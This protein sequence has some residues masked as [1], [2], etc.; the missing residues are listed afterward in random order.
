M[1][2]LDTP[3]QSTFRGAGRQYMATILIATTIT[4]IGNVV[5]YNWDSI[6]PPDKPIAA[7]AALSMFGQW[8][9]R[10]ADTVYEAQS[11]GFVAVYTH[12]MEDPANIGIEMGETPN[13]LQHRTRAGLHDGVVC[14]VPRGSYWRVTTY[15]GSQVQL[16]WL[17][18]TLNLQGGEQ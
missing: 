13:Q 2:G 16:W 4:A 5:A 3:T 14:P 11:D 8:E 12:G 7:P 1:N 15:G 18:V 6:F 9:S 17:P 10:D